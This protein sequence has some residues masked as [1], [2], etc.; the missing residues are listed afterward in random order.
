MASEKFTLMKKRWVLRALPW[1]I[2][3]IGLV[4]TWIQVSQIRQHE[5]QAGQDEFEIRAS[6][7]VAG[8]ERRMISHAQ[9]LRGVASLFAKNSEVTRDE[10]HRYYEGLQLSANF[11]GVQ[12]VGYTKIIP[13]SEKMNHIA[14]L[15]EEGF[16]NYDIWPAGERNPYSA[17]IFV[18]PFS[19]R[20]QRALGF[21][22][23]LEPIRTKAA[24]QA[25]DEGRVVISDKVT[26]VQETDQ[27][28]QAGVLMFTPVYRQDSPLGTVEQR[29]AAIRGWAYVSLRIKDLM[30]SYLKIEYA[31]FSEKIAIQIYSGA[32][33]N[34]AA[35]MYESHPEIE[36][37]PG[38]YKFVRKLSM[39]GTTWTVAVTPLP[40][41]WSSER[42]DENPQMAMVIGIGL[43]LLLA[44]V[45]K[46][47]I[48]SFMRVSGALQEI[49][50]AN[51][52]LVKQEELLRAIYDTS[53]VTI[54]LIDVDG[55]IVY[56]NQRTVEIFQYP[57]AELLGAE[58]YNFIAPD[59]RERFR[60]QFTTLLTGQVP[61]L[62]SERRYCRKN[63][64]AEF[65][66]RTTGRSFR[67]ADG[68]ISGIVVVIED[69]TELRKTEAAM[70]LAS[71]VFDASSSGII[72]TDAE[73]HIISVN[74]AFTR[75]TG[76]APE[77]VLGHKPSEFFSGAQSEHFY[78]E[79]WQ[80]IDKTGYWEGELLNRRKNGQL[81]PEMLSISRVLDP[82]GAVINYVS[83]FM[84]IT[85]RR[86]AEEKI[87]HLAHHDYLT[88]LPNRALLV[89]RATQALVLARRYQRQMAVIFIDLDRFKPINDEY[90]HDA[91]DTVLRA[92]A[93]RLQ[94]IVRT[95][96]TVCRQGGDEFVILL[97]EIHGRDGLK[98]L[99]Q[100]LL[101]AI[102]QPCEV[103]EHRLIVSASIGI[104]LYPEH[105]D[106]VDTIIQSADTA[107]YR[108]KADTEKHIC[109]ARN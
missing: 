70:R 66:G 16:D 48:D 89:E 38:S 79:M 92:I 22:M 35:L 19:G 45:A 80:A 20:N 67:D 33:M 108:A 68:N 46:V 4:L 63:N 78:R 52:N 62:T 59:Y 98:K 25:R 84:D 39:Y 74:P 91:G 2:I 30:Q 90:G 23:F 101:T 24:M 55:K 88:G 26:L 77:D 69:I 97:P 3:V 60:K 12:G 83:M 49:T 28:V 93:K 10:F 85:E 36:V 54:L 100:E 11:P 9:I 8:L 82:G 56:A 76:Y 106:S 109:F 99:A 75:I 50:N 81:F 1:L 87:Y 103:G 73:R 17:V 34:S 47:L 21:D 42:V 43:A 105:G 15:R 31:D 6:E 86:K 64:A 104:A 72:V 5:I 13:V 71:A 96:D 32:E 57:L 14:A 53:G 37:L 95:S 107:M 102:Q 41:Y 65:W 58:Y 40:A 51:R 27:D 94:A 29:R 44:L 7:L 61:S 18:E